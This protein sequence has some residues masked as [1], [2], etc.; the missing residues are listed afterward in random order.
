MSSVHVSARAIVYSKFPQQFSSYNVVPFNACIYFCAQA[1]AEVSMRQLQ[2]RFEKLEEDVSRSFNAC[3]VDTD[4]LYL[5]LYL[6]GQLEY[7]TYC[8]RRSILWFEEACM[9]DEANVS[10]KSIL[11]STALSSQRRL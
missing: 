9:S 3:L 11:Y 1:K 7:I 2:E 10:I 8:I 4:V 6:R 5:Y